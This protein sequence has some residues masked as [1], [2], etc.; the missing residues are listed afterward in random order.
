MAIDNPWPLLL[1]GFSL[2][3]GIINSAKGDKNKI[4][5]FLHAF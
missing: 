1:E 4:I 3:L 2:K 5:I